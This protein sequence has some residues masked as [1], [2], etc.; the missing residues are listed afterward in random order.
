VYGNVSSLH[1][2]LVWKCW[3]NEPR[4]KDNLQLNHEKMEE[5][6]DV[7]MG[8]ALLEWLPLFA[9]LVQLEHWWTV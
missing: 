6:V 5:I 3:L 9:R 2:D 4:K 1:S 7:K 8:A